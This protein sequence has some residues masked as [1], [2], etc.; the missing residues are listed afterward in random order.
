MNF[1]FRLKGTPIENAE[2][3][4]LLAVTQ[5]DT[6]A[7]LAIDLEKIIDLRVLDSTTLFELAIKNKTPQLAKLA[8]EVGSHTVKRKRGRPPGKTSVSPKKMKSKVNATPEEIIEE[9]HKSASY[10]AV[11]AASIILEAQPDEWL[12]T[13]EIAIRIANRFSKRNRVPQN[14]ILFKGF[15]KDKNGLIPLDFSSKTERN[16]TFH[17]SPI[18]LG[19]REGLIWCVKRGLIDQQSE[20]S[21]GARDKKKPLTRGSK[22]S[23]VFY[24]IKATKKA[25]EIVEMWGDLPK[26]VESFYKTRTA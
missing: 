10:W 6:K 2:A 25:T 1:Q 5:P 17:V 11:G 16:K 12:T 3:K 21:I 26:Y 20:V 14:S 13:R 4:A 23:R 7:P 9:L 8:F 22:M 18:Y 19:I 15:V 24:K